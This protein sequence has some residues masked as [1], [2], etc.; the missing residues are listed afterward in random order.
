[1]TNFFLAYIYFIYCIN[2]RISLTYEQFKIL[3]RLIEE[4]KIV[5]IKRMKVGKE[6]KTQLSSFT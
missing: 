6:G 4:K 3:T 1:M 5:F 2:F